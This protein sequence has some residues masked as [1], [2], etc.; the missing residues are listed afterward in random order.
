MDQFSL[1][2]TKTLNTNN[3]LHLHISMI[4]Q[5]NLARKTIQIDIITIRI[6]YHNRQK[7]NLNR[8]N[9]EEILL[10]EIILNLGHLMEILKILK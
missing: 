3:H 2:K 1:F 5:D 8:R 10:S 4:H 6:Y 9:I 7:K